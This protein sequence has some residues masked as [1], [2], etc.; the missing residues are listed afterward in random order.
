MSDEQDA[1]V[2]SIQAE[3]SDMNAGPSTN[4]ELTWT[5]A[6]RWG[7]TDQL[8]TLN[9]ITPELRIAAAGL[10]RV[11]ETVSMAK[12]IDTQASA[13]NTRPAWHV[14]HLE[15][16]RPYATADSLQVQT[17]GLASTHLDALGHMFL[18]GVGY[19][20]TAMT[21]AMNMA[22]LRRLD[23]GAMRSG[24]VTR[25]VLLDVA[26]A[27]GCEYLAAGAYV[28]RQLLLAAEARSGLTVGRGDALIVH[29]GL[30]RREASDGPED[31][32]VR[33]G[34]SQDAVGWLH[35]RQ[36][37]VYS[38]DCIER[39]PLDEDAAVPMPLHQLGIARLGLVLLDCPTLTNLISICHRLSR[40]DFL[41]MAAPLNIPG[42]TG[43]LVN[44]IAV[45]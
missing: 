37:A 27:A 12:P 14:M 17:H 28:D 1:G 21:E 34:L 8:G 2:R 44:P 11:G 42:G 18:N 29:V 38:G 9:Y 39:F 24:I 19:N 10:V 36:I 7:P 3:D 26:E 33:A 6:G 16:E 40:N 13:V 30:E 41:F 22:G 20:G 15:T 31:P 43:S 25:G 5:N 45:F 23:I 4:G 32:A 35:E